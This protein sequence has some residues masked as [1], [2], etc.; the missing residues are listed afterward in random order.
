M[1]STTVTPLDG[2]DS[3]P[4]P[5]GVEMTPTPTIV[6]NDPSNV[7]SGGPSLIIVDWEGS[8]DPANPKK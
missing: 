6:E 1:K 5:P 3:K 8:D 2:Q 4:T 7:G